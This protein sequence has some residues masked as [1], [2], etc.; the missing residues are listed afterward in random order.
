MSFQTAKRVLRFNKS[1][2]TCENVF[3]GDL[4]EN[5]DKHELSKDEKIWFQVSFSD[6]FLWVW[7]ARNTLPQFHV[8]F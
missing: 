3:N 5:E 4:F 2:I 6:L 7:E 1:E 8:K